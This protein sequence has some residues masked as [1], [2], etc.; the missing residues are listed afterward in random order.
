MPLVPGSRRN[1]L[2]NNRSQ[3]RPGP[4]PIFPDP[5]LRQWLAT[6]MHEGQGLR[7]NPMV[8]LDPGQVQDLRHNEQFLHWLTTQRQLSP[9]QHM[10]IVDMMGFDPWLFQQSAARRKYEAGPPRRAA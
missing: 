1:E 3:A 2:P 7:F 6:H 4:N 9:Y 8:H 10:Q 5:Y